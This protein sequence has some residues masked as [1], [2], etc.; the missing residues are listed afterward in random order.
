MR[1]A[2]IQLF[3]G[4][5]TSKLL[6]VAREILTAAS[7]GTGAGIGAYRVAQT[8]ILAPVNFLSGDSLN[9][10]FIPQYKRFASYST[11]QAQL[12][13][14]TMLTLFCFIGVVLAGSLFLLAP[15]WV[16]SIAPGFTNDIG[17][18]S[19]RMLQIMSLGIPF[20]LLSMLFIY[21]SMVDDDYI[22]ASLRPVWQN[23]GMIVGIVMAFVFS[24][25]QLLA[26][27]FTLSYIFFFYG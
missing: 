6:G 19:A 1:K 26:W 15:G 17:A 18:L 12:F 9:S 2:V 7:L 27:S 4:N 13:F 24:N 8:G 22:A 10:A 11:E 23:L 5:L 25:V 16:G 14:I 20:Y 3:S 21:R